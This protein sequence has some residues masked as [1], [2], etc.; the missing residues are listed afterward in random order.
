MAWFRD[1]VWLSR[2]S[3]SPA[4]PGAVP[5]P[6]G[7][8]PSVL[9]SLHT[10]VKGVH[11]VPTTVLTSHSVFNCL[12]KSTMSLQ[13][14]MTL[15]AVSSPMEMEAAP[16]INLAVHSHVLKSRVAPSVA[17]NLWFLDHV[18]K[19]NKACSSHSIPHSFKRSVHTF[20][21]GS[22]STEAHA[23]IFPGGILYL[24]R[25]WTSTALPTTLHCSPRCSA[26]TMQLSPP[27]L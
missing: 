10:S 1:L 16:I 15:M 12:N 22:S 2:L 23:P 24:Q 19:A 9:S 5:M 11:G 7:A 27:L 14:F 26:R 17:S 13:G 8:S 20:T 25:V 3:P 18:V 21:T 6:P 4:V